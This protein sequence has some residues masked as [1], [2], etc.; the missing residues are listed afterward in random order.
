MKTEIKLNDF[1]HTMRMYLASDKLNYLYYLP[2]QKIYYPVIEPLH[3]LMSEL[4]IA[5]LVHKKQYNS[6]TYF[7]K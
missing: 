7:S 1:I 2:E 4:N 5:E 6:L 3:K